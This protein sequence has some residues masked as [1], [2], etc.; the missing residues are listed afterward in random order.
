MIN[1]NSSIN[2]DYLTWN[3]IID[4]DNYCII[5]KKR[6]PDYEN[7]FMAAY[8]IGRENHLDKL[9]AESNR[10]TFNNKSA[11]VETLVQQFPSNLNDDV[12]EHNDDVNN[13]NDFSINNDNQL[14][15]QNTWEY[16]L[17][18]RKIR[19]H[20]LHKKRNFTAT[21]N[22]L[23][24][25]SKTIYQNTEKI[26][27]LYPTNT[28]PNNVLKD[29]E[30][31]K[32]SIKKS[33]Q[34]EDLFNELSMDR[35]T[36]KGVNAIQRIVLKCE[37]LDY[38][39]NSMKN[40]I[41]QQLTTYQKYKNKLDSEI[42]KKVKNLPVNE[43]GGF[44]KENTFTGNV[45]K[46]FTNALKVF[47]G[48]DRYF[49]IIKTFHLEYLYNQMNVNQCLVQSTLKQLSMLEEEKRQLEIHAKYSCLNSDNKIH[50]NLWKYDVPE[51]L[52]RIHLEEIDFENAIKN[53]DKR[54]RIDS[55]N[56]KVS[57]ILEIFSGWSLDIYLFIVL[58]ALSERVDGLEPIVKNS[59]HKIGT[60]SLG[61]KIRKARE[62]FLL[63]GGLDRKQYFQQSYIF[64]PAIKSENNSDSMLDNPLSIHSYDKLI[65]QKRTPFGHVEVND[66][67]VFF[68]ASNMPKV[69]VQELITFLDKQKN[70]TIDFV[71]F[72]EYL[73]L[74]IESHKRIICEPYLTSNIYS[75]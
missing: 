45:T 57:E 12:N 62:L 14:T 74:F 38:I 36:Q 34:F 43:L 31:K 2:E 47:L 56:F 37:E 25:E 65:Y 17:L 40:T 22:N 59:V 46:Q 72:I 52:K 69:H 51:V 7:I 5:D 44:C 24:K 70:G 48:R 54:L 11:N 15:V 55:G 18:L 41:N 53:I 27:N 35:Y 13:V 32:V 66:L 1:K 21:S 16:Y 26:I 23:L 75:V 73:P 42:I 3:T 61:M 10:Q 19:K 63:I 4:I 50:Y 68:Y 60:Q 6:I 58:A 67:K 64:Q 39:I 28:L 29:K 30:P 49:Q 33:I 8:L 20:L 71:T 9:S